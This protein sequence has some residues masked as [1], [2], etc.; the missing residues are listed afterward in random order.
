MWNL[1]KKFKNLLS[2]SSSSSVHSRPTSAPPRRHH[3]RSRRRRDQADHRYV[4]ASMAGFLSFFRLFVLQI[5][6]S[7]RPWPK[8]SVLVHD[9]R[10]HGLSMAV[11]ESMTSA[12]IWNRG[13][14]SHAFFPS[15]THSVQIWSLADDWA[16][17]MAIGTADLWT[18]PDLEA[19]LQSRP[20]RE[21]DCEL[22]W[23]WRGGSAVDGADHK[24]TARDH[25]AG[26]EGWRSKSQ[27]R[28]RGSF[29]GWKDLSR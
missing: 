6:R 20:R 17:S 29:H 13:S 4:Q 26:C 25:K 7:S 28:Q 12:Q 2:P 5:S 21:T 27:A 16:Q 14:G 3:Q 1:S 22:P 18:R 19:R 23:Q 9:R 15:M 24:P 8:S 11:E 10:Q